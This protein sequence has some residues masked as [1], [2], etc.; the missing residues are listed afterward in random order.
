[1]PVFADVLPEP[2]DILTYTM[3]PTSYVSPI[4][5]SM[6]WLL[7]ISWGILCI[8]GIVCYWKMLKK[9]W[10]PG[11]GSIIPFYNIYLYFKLAWRSGGWTWS[12]LCP[13]LFLIMVIIGC[14]DIAKRFGKSGRFGLGN[15]LLWPVFY[16]ILAFWKSTR[17]SQK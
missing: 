4:E 13:P 12:L 6:M 2:T 15:L 5:T 10:L 14:F 7:C 11:W 17:S 9:A 1:M 16:G 3:N 8:Y